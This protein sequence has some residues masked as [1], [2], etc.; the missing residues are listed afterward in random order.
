MRYRFCRTS[1]GAG[2]GEGGGEGEGAGAALPCSH[3]PQGPPGGGWEGGVALRPN[4]APNRAPVLGNKLGN[5]QPLAGG[6][7]TR[8]QLPRIR[9]RGQW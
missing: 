5:M 2:R 3:Q 4:Q 1:W 7:G 9:D 8:Q 6:P